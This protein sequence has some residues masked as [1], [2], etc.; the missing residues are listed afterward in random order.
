[1]DTSAS[2]QLFYITRRLERRKRRR[3]GFNA[4]V[5]AVHRLREVAGTS[6][7][8][9]Q[10]H[11]NA[12]LSL[13]AKSGPWARVLQSFHEVSLQATV[14]TYNIALRAL[15]W[16]LATQLLHVLPQRRVVTDTVSFASAMDGSRWAVC[17]ALLRHMGASAVEANL[18]SF[19]SCISSCERSTA[20]WFHAMGLMRRV[21]EDGIEVDRIAMNSAISA[22]G[23]AWAVALVLLQAM[24]PELISCNSLLSCCAQAG[25]WQLSLHVLHV[26]MPQLRV[27][28]N[29]ISFSCAISACDKAKSAW[30][31]ALALLQWMWKQRVTPNVISFSS[32]MSACEKCS[33]WE[34]ALE[35]LGAQ[36]KWDILP[37][38][39]SYNSAISAC[40]KAAKWELALLVSD[41]MPKAQL[42]PDVVTYNSAIAACESCGV[43]ATA[44]ELLDFMDQASV[45]PDLISF[46][47]AITACEKGFQWTWALH[48]LQRML[49]RDRIAPDVI[50]CNSIVSACARAS[51]WRLALA[52]VPVADE[53]TLSA[54][55]CA[56]EKGRAWRSALQLLRQSLQRM[57]EPE[58]MSHNSCL[59]ALQSRW[60][61]L[62][63]FLND[64]SWRLRP[65][66]A[67]FAAASEAVPLNTPQTGWLHEN[68]H[69]LG[70]QGL[71]FCTAPLTST[72]TV[73]LMA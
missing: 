2:G 25:Q 66:A 21:L 30:N 24:S 41:E 38:G 60:R 19:S 6:F 48:L 73:A 46:S 57:L 15:P 50:C 33:R 11:F 68:L 13:G 61:H 8:G 67:S 55:C 43:W 59:I 18:I 72:K 52:L 32:A 65:N 20:P 37:D 27:D 63:W 69:A 16:P 10:F 70:L 47:S 53:V 39:V 9:E 3:P 17:L 49:C 28:P 64:M 22:C 44:L 45:M 40:E 36:L 54:L 58:I 14:V 71:L 7:K 51:K 5:E 12:L 62:L 35:L 29:V 4:W 26:L 23:A 1:M 56:S 31:V 34:Q 42:S